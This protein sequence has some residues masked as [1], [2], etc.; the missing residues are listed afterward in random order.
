MNIMMEDLN[1]FPDN[2]ITIVAIVL[3][4]NIRDNVG[5]I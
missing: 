2:N 4:W 1:E 5:V 3:F